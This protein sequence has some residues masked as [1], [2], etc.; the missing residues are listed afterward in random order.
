[1]IQKGER[2]RD[3]QHKFSYKLFNIA[4]YAHIV[5]VLHAFYCNDDPYLCSYTYI[6]YFRKLNC[7]KLLGSSSHPKSISI[8]VGGVETSSMWKYCRA[9][10][11]VDMKKSHTHT[12]T[13][14]HTTESTRIRVCGAMDR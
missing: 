2:E 13:H 7:K 1:M 3:H 6:V 8:Y 10:C 9:L 11:F 4:S 5:L 12:H 14:T